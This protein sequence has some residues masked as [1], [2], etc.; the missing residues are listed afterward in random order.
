MQKYISYPTK[1]EDQLFARKELN[2][3][4]NLAKTKYIFMFPN[5]NSVKILK[6]RLF[7]NLRKRGNF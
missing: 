1:R 7:Y 3:E 6:K 4:V 2:L 5:Q